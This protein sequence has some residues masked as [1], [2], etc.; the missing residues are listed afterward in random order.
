[1]K[2]ELDEIKKL[3]YLITEKCFDD[4]DFSKVANKV[5]ATYL[6]SRKFLEEH[7]SKE[8]SAYETKS[9]FKL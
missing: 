4:N 1:M 9:S 6:E 8:P 7:S 2:L 3:A 5:F